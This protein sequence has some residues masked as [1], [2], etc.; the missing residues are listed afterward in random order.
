MFFSPITER[1]ARIKLLYLVF[2]LLLSLGAVSMIIPF[3]IM[4]GGSLE[5][6]KRFSDSGSI[7]RYIF[8]DAALWS[9]YVQA[10]YRNKNEILRMAWNDPNANFDHLT[11]PSEGGEEVKV[12]EKWLRGTE[13]PE[14]LRGLGFSDVAIATP[15]Y[16]NR[17]FQRWMAS[18]YQ[19]TDE[20]NARLGTTFKSFTSIRPPNLTLTGAALAETA[21]VKEYFAFCKTVPENRFYAWDAGAYYRSIFLPRTVGAE[22]TA[23]NQKFATAYRNYS[24]VPFP[25]TEPDIA[26][27]PWLLF[28][29]KLLRPE[30]IEF[31][32]SGESR[33]AASG[34]SKGDFIR[35]AARGE[36]LRVVSADRRFSDW[37]KSSQGIEDARIPQHEID[38]ASFQKEKGFWRGVFI[39]QNY[40]YVIDEI[41]INGRAMKNT[42]ILVILTIIGALTVNPLAAYAL[43][44]FKLRQGY[45][46]LLFFLAT[47]SFPA[48]V[49]MIPV[50]LQLKEMNLLNTFGALVLPGLANGFSIFLLKSFFDSLPKEL[51]EAAELDGASEWTMFW[52]IAMNL[53]KPILAVKVLG[54]FVSAYGAFFY[55][56]ILAPDPKIW[57]IMVY[58]Y[59]LQQ[60]ADPPV[61]Y[62]SLIIVAIPT[63]MIFVF[64]QNIILRGI[65]V[66][67]EK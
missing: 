61:V 14:Q 45:Y 24:E 42:A 46:I 67:S 59:Q 27:E 23:Y 4:L 8:D 15:Y 13:L 32:S 50:F 20:L 56:L 57:T 30:F 9:R 47:I 49:T 62:A 28:V 55:A 18:R 6:G 19:T 1:S 11:P 37:A 60:V 36:D 35:T 52:L 25:D 54:A 10:K 63:L 16:Y 65:A 3:A 53:S 12:W 29:T 17:Q 40:Q 41:F 66:P 51:Y 39:T 48:E 33:F 21:F 26:S 43:S 34:L 2:Y 58:I 38:S 22:I 64:C 7:P 44:R 31:T 5:P